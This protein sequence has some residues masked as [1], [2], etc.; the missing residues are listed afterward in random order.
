MQTTAVAALR[1]VLTTNGC[2]LSDLSDHIVAGSREIVVYR[3]RPGIE[4]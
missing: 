3:A 1:R 4:P 2:D